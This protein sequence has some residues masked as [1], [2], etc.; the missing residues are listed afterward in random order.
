MYA[1]TAKAYDTAVPPNVAT[2]SPVTVTVDQ[3]PSAAA[4]GPASVVAFTAAGATVPSSGAGPIPIWEMSCRTAG[5]RECSSSARHRSSVRWPRSAPSVHAHRDRQL[6]HVQRRRRG[7]GGAGHD[8]R[9]SSRRR[10]RSAWP[11]RRPWARPAT[12]RLRP[13][14]TSS[15]ASCPA[16]PLT[17]TWTRCPWSPSR[18]RPRSGP[19]ASS[20]M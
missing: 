4:S 8:L 3:P 12:S 17:T 11:R 10:R 15:S 6:R 16:Q 9:L 7:G 18:P 13:P 14:R 2:S 20:R 1:L 19:R 5:P